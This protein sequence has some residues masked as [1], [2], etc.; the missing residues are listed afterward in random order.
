LLDSDNLRLNYAAVSALLGINSEQARL[1]LEEAA[2]S[3][4]NA[5]VRRMIFARINVVS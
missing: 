1:L 2:A 4:P 5:K 3:H